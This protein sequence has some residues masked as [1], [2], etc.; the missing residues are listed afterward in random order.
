M[1]VYQIGPRLVH[2]A[3]VIEQDAIDQFQQWE[4]RN[5]KDPLKFFR[6][7]IL[8]SAEGNRKIVWSYLRESKANPNSL[9]Y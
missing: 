9:K 4:G 1:E 8:A 6:N 2:Q 5:T 3:E 7:N